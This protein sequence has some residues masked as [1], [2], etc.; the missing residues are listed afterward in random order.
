MAMA[1][2][3]M[4]VGLERRKGCQSS[5]FMTMSAPLSAVISASSSRW[6]STEAVGGK[7][8]NQ[9]TLKCV[10]LVLKVTESSFVWTVQL[11]ARIASHPSEIKRQVTSNAMLVDGCS[12]SALALRQMQGSSS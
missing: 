12:T 5:L 9:V 10:R 6:L 8:L 7:Q 11:S 1:N 4:H 3:F 2:G